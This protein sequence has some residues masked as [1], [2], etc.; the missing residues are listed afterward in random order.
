MYVR[1]K[2][3]KTTKYVGSE[4]TTGSNT[5]EHVEEDKD[6]DLQPYSAQ[7]LS[8]ILLKLHLFPCIEV[9][10]AGQVLSLPCS[11]PVAQALSGAL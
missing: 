6:V 11:S 7:T 3:C 10:L 5:A 1:L 8:D 4:F 2:Y 9:F